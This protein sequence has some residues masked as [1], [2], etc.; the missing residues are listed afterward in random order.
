MTTG[1]S[2]LHRQQIR[3]PIGCDLSFDDR[4]N[5][6]RDPDV[7]PVQSVDDREGGAPKGEAD[8]VDF[9]RLDYVELGLISVVLPVWITQSDAETLCFR[10]QLCR[11]VG[12]LGLISRCRRHEE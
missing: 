12:D 3:A 2:A 11:I 7:R 6:H 9:P 1:L 8:E 5:G 4:C 10:L